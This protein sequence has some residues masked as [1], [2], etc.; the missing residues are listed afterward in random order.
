MVNIFSI[1]LLNPLKIYIYLP[2]Y[3]YSPKYKPNY[4]ISTHQG[5]LTMK[6]KKSLSQDELRQKV[7][8]FSLDNKSKES[9]ELSY[10]TTDQG[11]YYPPD[12]HVEND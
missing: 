7:D 11:V 10:I 4:I 5:G 2:I 8:G 3:S 12:D 9:S 6:N 1:K